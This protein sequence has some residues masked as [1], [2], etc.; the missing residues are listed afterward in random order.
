MVTLLMV[1]LVPKI[2]PLN[3]VPL[4]LGLHKSME[5]A[6]T[7]TSQTLSGIWLDSAREG[8]GEAARFEVGA[9]LLRSYWT[10]NVLQLVCAVTLW[11]LEERRRARGNDGIDLSGAEE[12]EALPLST[13]DEED[14]ATLDGEHVKHSPNAYPKTRAIECC[15]QNGARAKKRK[16]LLFGMFRLDRHSMGD[17]LGYSLGEALG[18]LSRYMQNE[19]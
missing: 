5:M 6:S 1:I 13:I 16:I 8:A 7:A 2:L 11:R 12:Y 4:G 17:F 18:R 19:A 14:D 9:S 10:I 3:L 15:S